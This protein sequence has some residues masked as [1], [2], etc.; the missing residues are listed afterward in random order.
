VSPTDNATKKQIWN[1]LIEVALADGVYSEEEESLL[2]SFMSDVEN[3]SKVLE[4]ALNDDVID[5]KE[6]KE[7]F[8]WRMKI[9]EKAYKTAREDLFISED[10]MKILKTICKVILE[11]EKDFNDVS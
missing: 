3:Y 11:I 2:N 7:L 5:K 6:H 10:E 4:K 1:K 8:E 9:V